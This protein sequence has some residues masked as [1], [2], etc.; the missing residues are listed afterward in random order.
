MDTLTTVKLYLYRRP[1]GKFPES[2]EL[3]TSVSN[4]AGQARRMESGFNINSN[5]AW[6]TEK[7]KLD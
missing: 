5:E 2:V 7:T 4:D 1:R 3:R 6:Y